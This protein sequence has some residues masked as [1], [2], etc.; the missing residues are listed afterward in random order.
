[1]LINN[2]G[3]LETQTFIMIAALALNQPRMTHKAVGG[4]GV[5]NQSL[6]LLR[7]QLKHNSQ[8]SL[9]RNKLVFR[10]EML[11][12][13]TSV[14]CYYQDRHEKPDRSLSRRGYHVLLTVWCTLWSK[15]YSIPLL[16][17]LIPALFGSNVTN[18]I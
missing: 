10:S 7:E 9:T 4:V 5:V 11:A 2:Q 6:L 17:S 3:I 8:A 18:L 13:H 1:M 15:G 12:M 14:F 16:N